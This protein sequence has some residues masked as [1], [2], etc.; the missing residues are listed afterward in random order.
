LFG[1]SDLAD[2]Y[3]NGELV[4]AFRQDWLMALIKETRSNRDFSTRTIDTARWARE[5]VRRQIGGQQS[6][7]QQT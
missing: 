1:Y 3:P 2:A 4:D 6:V 7:M 5:Q